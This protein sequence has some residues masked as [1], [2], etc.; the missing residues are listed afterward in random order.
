MVTGDEN[1]FNSNNV[2]KQGRKNLVKVPLIL[3]LKA[4]TVLGFNLIFF[5]V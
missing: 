5:E 3:L 1:F 2:V 4:V